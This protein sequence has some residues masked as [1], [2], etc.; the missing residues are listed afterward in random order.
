MILTVMA[1]IIMI[2]ITMA[3]KVR[4]QY[5]SMLSAPAT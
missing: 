5:V 4:G 3:K 1:M 2:V